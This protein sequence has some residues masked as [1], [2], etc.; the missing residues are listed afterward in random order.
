MLTSAGE[1]PTAIRKSTSWLPPGRHPAAPGSAGTQS[2]V[3]VLFSLFG[4]DNVH[5]GLLNGEV[6][7]QAAFVHAN[8]LTHEV[9]G[10]AIVAT[11]RAA[12]HEGP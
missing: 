5:E 6:G 1:R 9:E 10:G 4:M 3:R 12:V 11:D 8:V 7:R 2:A